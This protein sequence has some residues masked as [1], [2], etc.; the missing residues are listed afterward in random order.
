M[1]VRDIAPTRDRSRSQVLRSASPQ[2][3]TSGHRDCPGCWLPASAGRPGAA[4]APTTARPTR[5]PGGGREGFGMVD[6]DQ[7]FGR[8]AVHLRRIGEQPVVQRGEDPAATLFVEVQR[9]VHVVDG[10]H[11]VGPHRAGPAVDETRPRRT[12]RYRAR[13]GGSPRRRRAAPH[14]PAPHHRAELD[15]RGPQHRDTECVAALVPQRQTVGQG[16]VGIVELSRNA[17][18]CAATA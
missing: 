2:P 14:P 9:R 12:A 4:D 15:G 3:R 17:C 16:G 10:V 11:P 8:A 18:A 7:R 6:T 13:P 5:V 1:T